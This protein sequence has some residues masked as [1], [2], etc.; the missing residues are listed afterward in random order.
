[1]EERAFHLIGAGSA[2]GRGIV[3]RVRADEIIRWSSSPVARRAERHP[4]GGGSA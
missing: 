3:E 1:M 2:V 4:W